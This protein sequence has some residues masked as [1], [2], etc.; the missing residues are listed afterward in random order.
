MSAWSEGCLITRSRA[1]GRCSWCKQGSIHFVHVVNLF[2]PELY[3]C[4][5]CGH[6]TQ[7]CSRCPNFAKAEHSSSTSALCALCSHEFSVWPETLSLTQRVRSMHCS[8]CLTLQVHRPQAMS[9]SVLETCGKAVFECSGCSRCRLHLIWPLH[10]QRQFFLQCECFVPFLMRNFFCTRTCSLAHVCQY[11]GA[12]SVTPDILCTLQALSLIEAPLPPILPDAC[13]LC[14][15]TIKMN[16]NM[17][18]TIHRRKA[19]RVSVANVPSLPLAPSISSLSGSSAKCHPLSPRTLSAAVSHSSAAAASSQ[20]ARSPAHTSTSPVELRP[21]MT[22]EELISVIKN[23]AGFKFERVVA[24]RPREH[25]FPMNNLHTLVRAPHNNPIK[26]KQRSKWMSSATQ[27]ARAML[28]SLATL[29]DDGR[30]PHLTPLSS[31]FFHH[32]HLDT[33]SVAELPVVFSPVSLS[34]RQFSSSPKSQPAAREFCSLSRVVF[35]DALPPAVLQ[36][37]QPLFSASL[38]GASAPDFIACLGAALRQSPSPTRFYFIVY[39]DTNSTLDAAAD[40]VPPSLSSVVAV[41]CYWI[42]T[43]FDM[44]R[45]LAAQCIFEIQGSCFLTEGV[46]YSGMGFLSGLW[47]LGFNPLSLDLAFIQIPFLEQVM[48]IMASAIHLFYSHAAGNL[49]Q[50]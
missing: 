17:L 29:L 3:E 7:H 8:K 1:Q 47:V 50:L 13:L 10:L 18:R 16:T 35:S 38:A 15:F 40:N 24:S 11:C 43:S 32:S 49:L 19:A 42:T 30:A 37:A 9:S 28:P 12:A 44:A 39:F 41:A 27:N 25:G 34:T 5:A 14:C 6:I 23:G 48:L 21:Q 46:R 45:Y 4:S 22:W 36:A 31:S 20:H 2:G 26:D 33:N